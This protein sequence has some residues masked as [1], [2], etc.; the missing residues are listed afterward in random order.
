MSR[1]LSQFRQRPLWSASRIDELAHPRGS[2]GIGGPLYPPI[3][4][5]VMLPFALG[6]HPQAAYFVMQYVQVFFCFAAGLAV[7]RLSQGNFW[8]PVASAVILLYPGSRGVIDLGQNSALTLAILLWG[9]RWIAAGRPLLGGLIWG[10]LA[11]KPV[12]ALSFLTL[13]LLLQQFRA[14]V[15]MACVGACLIL[16]TLPLVGTHSWFDW[17]S[18]GQQ[19][20]AI[21]NVDL[22][23][24]FF[25]RDALGLPRRLLLDFSLPRE[26]RQNPL[27]FAAGWAL[28]ALILELTWRVYWLRR[29][30]RT[31][32]TGPAPAFLILAHGFALTTSCITTP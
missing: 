27:A 18:V 28:W 26:Q 14:A 24:I 5:L 6:D 17:L 20:A 23:W 11:Y 4:A 22:N 21:Y 30:E 3:H 15:A 19:A 16:A 13:L 10:L 9:W 32:F 31:P 2:P 25:S 29:H 12:W 8:W 1:R 7:C